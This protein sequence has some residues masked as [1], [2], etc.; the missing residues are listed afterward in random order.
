MGLTHKLAP[1]LISANDQFRMPRAPLFSTA[2]RHREHLADFLGQILEEKTPPHD[3]NVD[4]FDTLGVD[5]RLTAALAERVPPINLPNEVQTQTL[6]IMFEGKRVV[7][8]NAPTG[9]GK[10]LAFLLPILTQLANDAASLARTPHIC[11]IIMLPSRELVHQIHEEIQYL[12]RD[13]QPIPGKLIIFLVMIIS[14]V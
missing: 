7:F 2:R 6:P 13:F 12:V 3:F 9:T 1:P 4:T 8:L 10:T 5:H 14:C 11:C